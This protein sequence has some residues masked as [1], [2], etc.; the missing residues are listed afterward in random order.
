M[1][2]AR[3]NLKSIEAIARRLIATRLAFGLTQ[4][5]FAVRAGVP[6]N[7]YNQYER[8]KSR[9]QL[10]YA[11]RICETYGVTLD[12]IYFGT[13]NGLQYDIAR[14]ILAY[15]D[16]ENLSENA[17]EKPPRRLPLSSTPKE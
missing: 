10:D 15:L 16:S 13:P 4:L 17:H 14:Q 7:T 5:E 11:V 1:S 3:E 12:W 9:P 8:A 2:T 6:G